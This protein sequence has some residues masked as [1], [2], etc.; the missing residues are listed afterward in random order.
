[1]TTPKAQYTKGEWFNDRS[2]RCI[3]SVDNMRDF[4][5]QQWVIARYPMR[6]SNYPISHEEWE[7]NG[8]LLAAAPDLARALYDIICPHMADHDYGC[9]GGKC[10]T[11]RA[12][13]ALKK[14]G[15]L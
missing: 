14:A 15:L 4:K 10:T 3:R 1:M 6:D 9:E 7:A 5:A 12:Q 13:M 11:V 2:G 8:M